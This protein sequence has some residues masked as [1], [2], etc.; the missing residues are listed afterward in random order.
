MKVEYHIC[1]KCG[2]RINDTLNS[3]CV[4]TRLAPDSPGSVGM[5]TRCKAEVVDLCD[6]C[7]DLLERWLE[8]NEV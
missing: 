4:I 2:A 5:L 1:D 7:I 8:N 6:D 3:R